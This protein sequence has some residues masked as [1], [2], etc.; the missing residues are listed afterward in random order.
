LRQGYP[1]GPA[2]VSKYLLPREVQVATVRV[3]PAV[4][5]P[6]ASRGIGGLVVAL[7][8]NGSAANTTATRIIVWILAAILLARMVQVMVRWTVGYFVITSQRILLCTG[9]LSRNVAMT[10]MAQLVD[11]SFTRSTFGRLLGYGTLIH[12]GG[13]RQDLIVDYL[14]YPEQLYLLISGIL[15]PKA[16]EPESADEL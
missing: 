2:A 9:S 4:L 5:I 10:P 16:D 12:S 6:W 14:P 15:Y 11:V 3:H 13:G 1:N 7:I 8:I